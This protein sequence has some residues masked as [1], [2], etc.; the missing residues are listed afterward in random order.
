VSTGL[1]ELIAR[2]AGGQPALAG[3]IGPAAAGELVAGGDPA[4]MAALVDGWRQ[5][6]PEAGPLYW[7]SRCW[8]LIIWQPLYLAV[9]AV[10]GSGAVP[11]LGTLAQRVRGGMVAGYALE[12]HEPET[13]PVA[14]AIRCAADEAGTV[15]ARLYDD[16]TKQVRLHPKMASRLQADSLLSAL[17]AVARARPDWDADH[18]VALGEAWLDAMRLAGHSGVMT[19][20]LPGG[21]RGLG[22]ARKVC[23]QHFRRA[24]GELCASCPKLEPE[25]RLLRLQEEW[26][27]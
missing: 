22:L 19:F 9:W 25:Q 21:G 5:R 8:T 17:L 6:H 12:A 13:L 16:L 2:I 20:D 15:A 23:C 10:H 11:R 3:R 27:C 4:P 24:D 18:T 26:M 1:A 7:A 14:A